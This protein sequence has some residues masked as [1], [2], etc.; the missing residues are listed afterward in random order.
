MSF[1][2]INLYGG[3]DANVADTQKA[4]E[5]LESLGIPFVT[6]FYSD[7]A[8]FPSVFA[9]VS[10]WFARDKIEVTEFPFVTY[11]TPEGRKIARGLKEIKALSFKDS[12][13]K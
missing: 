13:A 12:T 5:Y 2:N 8:Q 9:P 3:L 11:D 10:S 6:L 4:K 7:P 1:T